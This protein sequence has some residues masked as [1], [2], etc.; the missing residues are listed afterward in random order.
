MKF[1]FIHF[2]TL[3]TV[4]FGDKTLPAFHEGV[5]ELLACNQ[6][7]LEIIKNFNIPPPMAARNLAI[8]HIA[9]EQSFDSYLKNETCAV[10]DEGQKVAIVYGAVTVLKSLYPSASVDNL[11]QLVSVNDPCTQ[12]G[13]RIGIGMGQQ[14]LISRQNDGSGEKGVYEPTVGPGAWVPTAPAFIKNPVLPA[15]GLVTPFAIK[16]TGSLVPTGPSLTSTTYANDLKEV[17]ELGGNNSTIRTVDQTH[18]AQFWE[19]GTGTYTPPGQWNSIAQILIKNKMIDLKTSLAIFKRMNVA[20]ADAGI[21]CWMTKYQYKFWRPITAATELP[22]S[23]MPLLITPPH[24][25]FTSGHSSFSSA[26]KVVLEHYFGDRINF[27]MNHFGLTRKF[28]SLSQALNE[29]GRSRIY[30]G[31]HFEYSNMNGQR[32]GMAT[33]LQALL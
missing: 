10:Q 3:V 27:Q 25:E 29:A 16:S 12:E 18:I 15:W 14:I 11:I 7:H 1:F 19:S 32:I 22:T 9:T 6:A 26:A 30:G 33:A 28:T 31:I 2:S 20:V 21:V 24:P 5:P 13:Q 8:M 4:V 23:W 17:I